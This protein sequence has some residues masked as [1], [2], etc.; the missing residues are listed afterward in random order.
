[1]SVLKPFIREAVQIAM[2]TFFDVYFTKGLI[3]LIFVV[4]AVALLMKID[5]TALDSF[6]IL[7]ASLAGLNAAKST[8]TAFAVKGNHSQEP[9][10]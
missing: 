4:N 2:K 7:A 9:K 6:N 1:M 5:P 3:V 10:V 8:L